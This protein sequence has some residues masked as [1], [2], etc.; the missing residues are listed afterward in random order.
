MRSWKDHAVIQKVSIQVFQ[1]SAKIMHLSSHEIDRQIEWTGI[2]GP[3]NIYGRGVTEIL[4][5]GYKSIIL[6]SDP[7]K[8]VKRLRSIELWPSME[9]ELDEIQYIRDDSWVSNIT[10]IF[11][12]LKFCRFPRKGSPTTRKYILS[13]KCRSSTVVSDW[14]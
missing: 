8:L 5:R 6:E 10:Y 13:S 2:E 7:E 3:L 14:G 11:W 9:L 4:K 1:A 12:Y